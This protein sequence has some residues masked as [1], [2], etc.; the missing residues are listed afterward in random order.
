MRSE[1]LKSMM[2]VKR[3]YRNYIVTLYDEIA[4]VTI[5]RTNAGQDDWDGKD[6]GNVIDSIYVRLP[7]IGADND[8]LVAMLGRQMLAGVVTFKSVIEINQLLGGMAEMVER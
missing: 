5:L 4:N 7:N 8:G 1:Q 2:Q 3:A 6:P